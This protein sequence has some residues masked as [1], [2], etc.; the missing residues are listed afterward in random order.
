MKLKNVCIR[1][2]VF[3]AI[4]IVVSGV[5]IIAASLEFHYLKD[6]TSIYVIQHRSKKSTVV[7]MLLNKNEQLLVFLYINRK[8]FPMGLLIYLF[9][10][11]RRFKC[12]TGDLD[13]IMDV[14][15]PHISILT[16]RTSSWNEDLIDFKRKLPND[17]ISTCRRRR[18]LGD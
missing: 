7:R 3:F 11:I 1:Q 6:I 2:L 12:S 17:T 13:Y 5:G 15:L 10:L 18:R 9:F 8:I 4:S 16:T 14:S